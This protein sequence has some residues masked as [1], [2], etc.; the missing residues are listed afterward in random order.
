MTTGTANFARELT[1][2]VRAS[3]LRTMREFAES[4]IVH[5][6]GPFKGRRFRCD[7]QPWTRLWFEEL[8]SGRW[9]RHVATGPSQ[10]GKSLLCY[11]IPSLYFLCEYREDV[12][13]GAPNKDIITDKWKKEMRPTLRATRYG[14][15]LPRAGAGSRGGEVDEIEL[16]NGAG[17]RFLTGGSDDK[18]RAS[19]TARILLVTETDGMDKSAKTSRESDQITQ[20]EMRV[21][22]FGERALVFLEC[23][24]SIPTGRTWREYDERGSSGRIYIRCQHCGRFVSPERQHLVGWQ[25]AETESEARE[26]AALVCPDCGKLWTEEERHE[27]NHD[28]ILV[29]KGQEIDHKRGKTTGPL[30]ETRTLG[31]R[32]N[33]ANNLLTTTAHLAAKHWAA[34]RDPDESNAEKMLGQFVWAVPYESDE[35]D[36]VTLDPQLLCRRTSGLPRGVAPDVEGV[37]VTCGIDLGKWLAHWVAVAWSGPATGRVVEYGRVEVPSDDLGVEKGLLVALGEFADLAEAGWPIGSPAAETRA[38]ARLSLVDA[39]FETPSVRE[40]LRR[41][42][43]E[44]ILAAMGFGASQARHHLYRQP[45]TTGAVVH[46]LGDEYHVVHQKEHDLFVVEVN[47]DH[48]KTFVHERLNVPRDAAGAVTL[49][50]AAPHDHLSFAKHLTAEKQV[51]EFVAGKGVVRRWTQVHKNNHWLDALYLACAGGHLCGVRLEEEPR[52]RPQVAQ[53]RERTEESRTRFWKREG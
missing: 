4:E 13:Q 27:A 40:F 47:S 14:D 53:R 23:T 35:V 49:Y 3:R 9:S 25:N 33:S 52:E 8:D 24:V 22:S 50:D 28:C 19:Y 26:K 10:T 11:V 44:R 31:F 12:I 37:V 32:W 16:D 17:V 51:E 34:A 42:G 20:L 36:L 6:R 15:L 1:R 2:R 29:H 48:W 39:R 5:T 30:P 7:R 18:G 21:E 46:F 38:S 45:K 43:D 41:R